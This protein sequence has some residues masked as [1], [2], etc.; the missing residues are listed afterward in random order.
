MRRVSLRPRLA[1][2]TDFRQLLAELHPLLLEGLDL[3]VL[4]TRGQGANRIDVAVHFV[5]LETA[6][7]DAQNLHGLAQRGQ[8][9]P[10]VRLQLEPFLEIRARDAGEQVPALDL[11][12]DRDGQLF[13]VAGARRRQLDD[14]ARPDEDAAAL[15]VDRNLAEDR[16]DDDGD[17]EQTERA[18]WKP[19]APIHDPQ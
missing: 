8:L 3:L 1:Q 4:D 15:D 11:R 13:Q 19:A 16:P 17:D 9:E 12:P 5:A 10:L 6:G 18:Q 2:L 14:T 7:L